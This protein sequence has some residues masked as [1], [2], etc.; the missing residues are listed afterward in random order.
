MR[1][2]EERP[3]EMPQWFGALVAHIEEPVFYSGL[4]LL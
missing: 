4:L 2:Q 3:K 1:E